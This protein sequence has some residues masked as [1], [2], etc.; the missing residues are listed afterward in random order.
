MMNYRTPDGMNRRHFMKHLAGASALAAPA[1][2]LTHSFQ[3]HAD[4]LKRNHKSR[5]A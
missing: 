1:M 4:T 2:S 5:S 3:A